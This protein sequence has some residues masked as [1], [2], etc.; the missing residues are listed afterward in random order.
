MSASKHGGELLNEFFVYSEEISPSPGYLKGWGMFE[1]TA[2]ALRPKNEGV[3][4]N[5]DFSQNWKTFYFRT[6][7]QISHDCKF[8][9][10]PLLITFI[11]LSHDIAFN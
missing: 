3:Q 6:P 9:L 10:L 8:N 1:M 7:E 11:L 4:C 2:V 5:L